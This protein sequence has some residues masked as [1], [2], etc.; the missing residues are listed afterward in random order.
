MTETTLHGLTLTESEASRLGARPG[1]YRAT[2]VNREVIDRR[3]VATFAVVGGQGEY[4]GEVE[5]RYRGAV[6]P[7]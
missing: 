1:L 7:R 4:L 5:R 3:I 6:R 2:T